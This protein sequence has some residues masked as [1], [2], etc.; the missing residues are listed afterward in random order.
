MI[1]AFQTLSSVG[2]KLLLPRIL[3]H[4]SLE[5]FLGAIATLYQQILIA[6]PLL[7]PTK[8]AF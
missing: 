7:Q 1:S 8:H 6:M 3:N 4:D 5:C 2:I